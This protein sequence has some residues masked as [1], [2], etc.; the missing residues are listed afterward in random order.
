MTALTH[1]ERGRLGGLRAGR[2]K[3]M[4]RERGRKAAD[5][6]LERYGTEHFTRLAYRRHGKS[7]AMLTEKA[8]ATT[9]ATARQSKED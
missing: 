4:A 1:A 3:E 9:P 2:N 7:V 6:L 5:T 8:G